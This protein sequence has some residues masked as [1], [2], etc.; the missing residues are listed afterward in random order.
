MGHEG[1]SNPAVTVVGI[2]AGVALAIVVV[3]LI[4]APARIGIA[5]WIVTVLAVMG[6]IVAPLVR[7]QG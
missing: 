2:V 5:G 6:A 1:Q 3:F 7:K 4:F